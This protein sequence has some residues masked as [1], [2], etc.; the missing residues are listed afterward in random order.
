MDLK[1][2]GTRKTHYLAQEKYQL[3]GGEA[4][5]LKIAGDEVLK[6]KCPAG[7]K[8]DVEVSVHITNSHC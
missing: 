6:E 7:L 2:T 1:R 4:I 3:T 5:K 8:W